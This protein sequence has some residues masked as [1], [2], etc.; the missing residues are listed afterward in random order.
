MTVRGLADVHRCFREPSCFM[1]PEGGGTSVVTDV[2]TCVPDY[3]VTSQK[4][5]MS[6]V[7]FAIFLSKY[8]S[9]DRVKDEMGWVCGMYAK[10]I[11]ANSFYW[12]NLKEK[13]HQEGLR[14]DG[15]IILKSILKMDETT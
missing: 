12:G 3:T 14:I 15:K 4:T 7:T 5:P 8:Y 13:D 9:S 6:A 10:T 2:C 1:Y 11:N